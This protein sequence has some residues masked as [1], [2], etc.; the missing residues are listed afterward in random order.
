MDWVST[1]VLTIVVIGGLLL[2]YRALK[3]P[4]DMLFGFLGRGF[5]WIGQSIRNAGD[6]SR[7]YVQEIRYG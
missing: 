7:N 3:E 5:A 6:N 2:F 4:M 1:I